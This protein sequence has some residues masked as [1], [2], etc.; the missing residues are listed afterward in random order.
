MTDVLG[1]CLSWG[2]G[3]VVV[4][5]ADGSVVSIAIAEIVTGKPIPP[6]EQVRLRI[7]PKEAQLRALA[8]WPDLETAALGGWTLR[9]SNSS[10]ARR[11]NSVLAIGPAE[12][13]DPISAATEHYVAAGRRPIAMVLPETPEHELFRSAGWGP[14]SPESDALFQMAGVA[15]A[16]RALHERPSYAVELTEADD[17]V[18]ATIGNDASGFATYSEGWLGL[19]TLEVAPSRRRRGLGLAVV[20]ALLDWGAERGATTAYLQVLADNR[21]A[22]GLYDRLGFT[23]HH[24]YRYLSPSR[25]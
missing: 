6:R 23:T 13:D 14:E 5:R 21:A 10:P 20:A 25:R 8:M 17:Q 18:S 1:E 11:A 22:L 2:P 24:A 7:P 15:M 16:R 12:I 19:R 9:L 3:D 4:R